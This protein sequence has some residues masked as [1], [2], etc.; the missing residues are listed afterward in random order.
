MSKEKYTVYY[1]GDCPICTLEINNL[2]RCDKQRTMRF[3]NLHEV[4]FST[5]ELAKDKQAMMSRIHAQ[6]ADGDWET[7]MP[8]FRQ[9]YENVGMGRLL[10]WTGWRGVSYVFDKLY[11]WF[12]DNRQ[13]IGRLFS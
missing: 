7:G 4:D 6:R 5:H 2:K 9:A 13:W 1:D 8:V 3:I 12:A 11:A 10:G